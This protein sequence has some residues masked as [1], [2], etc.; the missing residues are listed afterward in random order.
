MK[1]TKAAVS[2]AVVAASLWGS[3]ASAAVQITGWSRDPAALFGG[4]IV[5]NLGLNVTGD[6][7][8]FH[9]T[10]FDT[11][12]RQ[13]VDYYS[14]CLD[15]ATGF[16]TF[17]DFTDAPI[18]AFLSDNPKQAQLAALLVHGN[19]L[20]DDASTAA[21]A[22]E[23]SA[24]LSLAVWEIIY[25]GATGGYDVTAGNFH[26]YGDAALPGVAGRANQYLSLASSGSWAAP[27]SSI[28]ALIPAVS[29]NGP[30]SQ[31][32]VYLSTAVPEPSVWGMMIAGFGAIGAVMRRQRR[33]IHR[34]L[35]AAIANA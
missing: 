18:S 11:D 14:F 7:G 35:A 24:A 21:D 32:Q 19:P 28:R 15:I 13:A 30:L 34:A 23:I 8:R 31:A 26:V 5:D 12:T 2:V 10:G 22:S 25:E 3:S 9:A 27:A 20:I 16:F 17:V 1:L 6:V 33:R 4:F 29:S